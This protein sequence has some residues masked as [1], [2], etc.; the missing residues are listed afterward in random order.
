[1]QSLR[2][3]KKGFIGERARLKQHIF[4]SSLYRAFVIIQQGAARASSW[5]RVQISLW[6]HSTAAANLW[7]S[8]TFCTIAVS[9]PY[10]MWKQRTPQQHFNTKKE[11][12]QRAE[13]PNACWETCWG[14]AA[15][16]HADVP[17]EFIH[18]RTDNE[19]M[20][21]YI[22][23]TGLALVTVRRIDPSPKQSALNRA[24]RQ[25]GGGVGGGRDC[26]RDGRVQPPTR[27]R[28]FKSESQA[29]SPSADLSDPNKPDVRA[30]WWRTRRAVWDD[31]SACC[32]HV[33]SA[34][35]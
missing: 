35:L 12:K 26:S 2:F 23:V 6:R 3:I 27:R 28:T 9:L 7:I 15:A 18:R 1:M 8:T 14:A 21:C 24:G 25:G 33:R 31:A 13:A 4:T 29:R 16:F 11:W 30:R 5:W 22:E 34:L 20:C 32:V 17:L 19:T 10:Q